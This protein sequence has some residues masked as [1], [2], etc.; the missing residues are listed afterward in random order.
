MTTRALPSPVSAYVE[1]TNTFNL[2]G[3]AAVF[4]DEVLDFYFS[5]SGAKISALIIVNNKIAS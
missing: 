3:L 4:H 1:A 5:V 2:E